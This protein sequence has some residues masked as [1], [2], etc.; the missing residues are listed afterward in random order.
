MKS[1]EKQKE[2]QCFSLFILLLTVELDV[3]RPGQTNS[4]KRVSSC[5]ARI[6][7]ARATPRKF[8]RLRSSF[9]LIFALQIFNHSYVIPPWFSS[10][11]FWNQCSLN[12][13][14]SF[15][16]VDFTTSTTWW[17]WLAGWLASSIQ[18]GCIQINVVCRLIRPQSPATRLADFHCLLYLGKIMCSRLALT[19]LVAARAGFLLQV[20]I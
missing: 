15:L 13:T 17:G 8:F 6:F 18:C 4:G 20:W 11:I 3:R 10:T 19:K 16:H 14:L 5:L 1:G 9:V 2:K 12:A 7:F